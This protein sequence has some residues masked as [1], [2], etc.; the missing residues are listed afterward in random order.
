MKRMHMGEHSIKESMSGA[1]AASRVLDLLM[2]WYLRMDAWHAPDRLLLLH[3]SCIQGGSTCPCICSVCES[4]LKL[5]A[6]GLNGIPCFPIQSDAIYGLQ[7]CV[8]DCCCS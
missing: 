1:G 3:Q 2:A 6:E 8:P 4:H 7:H 5:S